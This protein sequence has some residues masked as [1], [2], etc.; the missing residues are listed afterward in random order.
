MECKVSVSNILQENMFE[1]EKQSSFYAT[2]IPSPTFYKYGIYSLKKLLLGK[3]TDLASLCVVSLWIKTSLS[4]FF[5]Q[6][7][8]FVI[9]FLVLFNHIYSF[10]FFLA[11]LSAMV[12]D[13]IHLHDE[14][15]YLESSFFDMPAYK[16]SWHPLLTWLIP[17]ATQGTCGAQSWT[18]LY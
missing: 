18:A 6:M 13:W 3:R 12:T 4:L 15:N 14:I 2:E 9:G 1:G 8:I 7:F 10:S 16:L 11:Y 5:R 17:N